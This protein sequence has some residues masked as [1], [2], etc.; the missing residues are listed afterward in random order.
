MD[1]ILPTLIAFSALIAVG[2]LFA[3]QRRLVAEVNRLDVEVSKREES[4]LRSEW[5]AW[6]RQADL[7]WEG[8]YDK[9]HRLAGRLDRARRR[10]EENPSSQ[11]GI[12][13]AEGATTE[14]PVD[15]FAMNRKLLFPQ[16][17]RG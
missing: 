6:R 17:P 15:I 8:T 1:A 12:D 11:P 5:T 3:L 9:L 2:V 13:G 10:G 7:E 4:G 14:G 16:G